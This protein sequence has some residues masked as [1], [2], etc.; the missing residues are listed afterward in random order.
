MLTHLL[1]DSLG[2]NTKTAL[3]LHCAAETIHL[4]HTVST[5]KFGLEAKSV[6]NA[7]KINNHPSRSQMLDEIENLKQEIERLQKEAH[8]AE[9]TMTIDNQKKNCYSNST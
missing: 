9:C 3:L 7:C 1:K 4:N 5:L 6:I 2:G 8:E